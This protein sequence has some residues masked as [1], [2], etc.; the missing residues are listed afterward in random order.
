VTSVKGLLSL[1]NFE[2]IPIVPVDFLDI[3]SRQGNGSG[4]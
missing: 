2:G 1:E 4:P 3:V